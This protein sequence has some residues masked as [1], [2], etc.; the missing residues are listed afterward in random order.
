MCN[1]LQLQTTKKSYIASYSSYAK[2]RP[3]TLSYESITAYDGVIGEVDAWFLR[4]AFG[5]I[6][7]E[8]AVG[9]STPQPR[10][11]WVTVRRASSGEAWTPRSSQNIERTTSTVDYIHFSSSGVSW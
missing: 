1:F 4:P 5:V 10:S 9:Q 6:D 7:E 11:T 3:Y 2:I 8:F